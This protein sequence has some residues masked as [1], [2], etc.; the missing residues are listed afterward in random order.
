MIII[1][2]DL[3]VIIEFNFKFIIIKIAMVTSFIIV[4][5]VVNFDIVIIII[6]TFIMA[7]I[8]IIKIF[9]VLK[10]FAAIRVFINL[11]LY[12]NNK[13]NCLQFILIFTTAAITIIIVSTT[14]FNHWLFIM[15]IIKSLEKFTDY[16][17]IMIM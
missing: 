14:N 9:R 4:I 7:I 6:S 13:S 5:I 17:F 11:I 2:I 1:V 12:I 15:N 3:A 10:Q 16:N 8:T